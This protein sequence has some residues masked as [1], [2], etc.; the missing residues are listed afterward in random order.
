MIN[1]LILNQVY[2][3]TTQGRTHFWSHILFSMIAFFALPN[4]QGVE[5]AEL[6]RLEYQNQPLQIQVVRS[7][8]VQQQQLQRT[9][10]IHPTVQ[11]EKQ[12]QILPHFVTQ[13]YA[14]HAPI[15]GSPY[16]S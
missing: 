13:I 6:P 14:K 2:H 9:Q 8:F 11:W 12:P 10:F 7:A 15:R 4:V 5:Q 3:R 16:F 1:E